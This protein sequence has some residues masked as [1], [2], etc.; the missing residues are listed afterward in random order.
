M[1]RFGTSDVKGKAG[2]SFSVLF[3]APNYQANNFDSSLKSAMSTWSTVSGSAWR[4]NFAGYSSTPASSADG[5]MSVTKGGTSFPAGVLAATLT[6]A[7]AST[8]EILDS[9]IFVNPVMPLSTAPGPADF[10][11]ESVLLHEMGHGFGLDHNDGCYATRTVMQSS[12]VPGAITRSLFPPEMDGVR[13]LYPAPGAPPPSVGITAAPSSVAFNALA[14]GTAPTPQSIVLSAANGTGWS[15][16][17]STT[18]GGNWLSVNP[19]SGTGAATLAVTVTT[20]GLASGFYS[21]RITITSGANSAAVAVSLN[22]TGVDISPSALNFSAV[23]GG[24]APSPQTLTLTG[25]PGLGWSATVS[26]SSGGGWLRTSSTSGSLP[27]GITVFA[28]TAGLAPDVYSGKI[29]LAAAG[30][31]RDVPVQLSLT[32]AA[33]L[34]LDP[35]QILLSGTAGST[36]PTCGSFSVRSTGTAALDWTAASASAWL[37]ISPQSGRSPSAVSL[38]VSAK[39]LSPGLYSGSVSIAAAAPNSPQTVGVAFTITASVA[40]SEGGVVNAASFLP[41]QPVAAGELVSLFG[42]NLSAQTASAG[43]FPLPTDLGDTRVLVGGVAARLIYVSP[44]QINLVTPS[45]LQ[46]AAGSTTTLT[47]FNGRQ[48][49]TAVRIAVA[50][51][52]PGVFT[53]LGNGAGA[54][55]I[56]HLDGSLVSRKAPLAA[57][58]AFSVYLSGLGPLDQTLPDGAAAPAEPLARATSSVRLLVDGQEASVLFAG[59]S[60]GFAGL[61]VVVA[62]APGTLPRRFPEIAVEVQGTRSNRVTAGGPSLFDLAPATV[63]PGAD[64][65]LTLRGINLSP[66]SA[67]VVAGST[68]SADFADGDLQTLRVTIP[69][70]LISSVGTLDLKVIDSEAPQEPSSNSLSLTVAR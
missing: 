67:I 3:D 70:R 55:A 8:G 30:V 33:Q 59:A 58:E 29:T 12:I 36:V 66:S 40:V 28:S 35:P 51:Q 37:S 47:V 23:V 69:A 62:T 68:L 60:P 19:P 5:R 7:I 22:L 18:N 21:G 16:A 50:R 44:G 61:Q 10:D 42:I 39:D 24:L 63:S 2:A 45:A 57:G 52:A 54:G 27:A 11:F 14:G 49:S 65:T 41:A 31:T 1:I 13:Y 15:A 43:S 20:A 9:D 48:A 4:Y 56:T 26:T 34:S 32:G 38:C 17:A 6:T 53:A 25:P 64:A 46:S